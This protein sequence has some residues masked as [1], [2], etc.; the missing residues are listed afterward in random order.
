MSKIK[1]RFNTHSLTYEKVGFSWKKIAL[2]VLSYLAI[3][4]VFTAITVFI[5]FTYFDSPK[6]KMQKREIEW[7]TYQYDILNKRLKEVQSV[8]GDLEKRDDN[9]Y[10]MVFEA[11]PIA[12]EIRKAG[13]GGVDRYKELE[14]YENSKLIIE[15]T[16]KI[17]QVSKQLYIQSK[18]FDEVIKMAKNKEQMLSCI[19]A[20]QPISSKDLKHEPSGYG[21]RM[22]PI[23]KYEKFHAGMDFTANNGTKIYATGDGVIELAE[24]GSG[25]GNH[26]VIKHG[27]GYETLYGHMEKIGVRLGQKV[28][29]GELIGYVG[30]SGLSAGPHVHY[31]VHKNGQAVN[32]VNFYY[33]DLTPAEYKQ[34][35]EITSHASQSFD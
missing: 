19:P 14:G 18:S 11:D 30:N 2:K 25:Y 33:N 10:R 20:I 16:K 32:P 24:Y 31:E 8:L 12:N 15:S 34:M 5:A 4:T 21:M 35:I 17:D 9:I 22:H 1:Y 7:M 13:F 27:Y 29:R 26:V 3:G 6:E 23:Y 28:K